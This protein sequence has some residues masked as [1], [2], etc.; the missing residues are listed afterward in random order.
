MKFMNITKKEYKRF[1]KNLDEMIL[2]AEKADCNRFALQHYYGF[3]NSGSV[4]HLKSAD[5]LADALTSRN[6]DFVE[7]LMFVMNYDKIN[8]EAI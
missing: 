7:F 4:V 1:K 2:Y 6:K 8:K 3:P 5:D